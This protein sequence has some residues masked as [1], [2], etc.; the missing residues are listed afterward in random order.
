MRRGPLL[1]SAETRHHRLVGP[2]LPSAALQK[3][4][5]VGSK[6]DIFGTEAAAGRK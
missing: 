4:K 2:P 5:V 3:D 1:L 6:D